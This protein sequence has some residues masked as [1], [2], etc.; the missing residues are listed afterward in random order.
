[1]EIELT[2]GVPDD[3]RLAMIDNQLILINSLWDIDLANLY[4]LWNEQKIR[5]ISN[6]MKIIMKNQKLIL[7]EKDQ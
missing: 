2:E 6:A 1:M 7:S 4:D 5:V 3:P